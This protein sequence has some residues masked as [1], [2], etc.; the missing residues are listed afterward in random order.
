MAGFTY[1]GN[2]LKTSYFSGDVLQGKINLTLKNES[3]YSAITSNFNGSIGI[4]DLLQKNSFIEGIDYNCSTKSCI[5]DYTVKSQ[6]SSLN[7][8]SGS[9]KAIGFKITGKQIDLQSIKFNINSD[10]SQSCIGQLLINVLDRNETYIQNNRYTGTMCE[11]KYLGCFEE[12]LPSQDYQFAEITSGG[13]CEKIT[14][15]AGPAYSVGAKIKNSTQGTANLRMDMFNQDWE[16]LGSCN[17]PKHSSETQDLSCIVNYSGPDVRD[18]YICISTPSS[19]SA[20]YQIQFEQTQ[21]TCGTDNLGEINPE[22]FDKDY[23]IF[24]NVM[25]FDTFNVEVNENYFQILTGQSLKD[26]VNSY[27]QD[28]YAGDCSGSGCFI[29]LK[30]IAGPEQNIAFS[31]I[32]VKYKTGNTL[33]TN[34]DL[35]ELNVQASKISS[36]PLGIEISHAGITIPFNS[37]QEKISLYL[38]GTKIVE[39][40]P[41]NVSQSFIFD[42]NPKFALLGIDTGFEAVT[43]ESISSSSWTFGDGSSLSSSNKSIVHKYL[44]PGEYN[45]EVELTNTKGQRAK[46]TFNVLVGNPKESAEKLLSTYDSRLAN[47]SKE[48][49][50]YPGWIAKD[51]EKKIDPIGLNASLINLKSKYDVSTQDQEYAEIVTELLNLKVPYR[52]AISTS[53]NFPLSIGFNSIDSGYL[54]ELSGQEISDLEKEE[55]NSA[56]IQW[57]NEN[58]QSNI[59]MEVISSFDDSGESALLTK[60]K[61]KSTS[62]NPDNVEIPYL[63]LSYPVDGIT[64]MQAYSEK[65]L[66]S[67][68][69][70]PLSSEANEIEFLMPGEIEVSQIGAYISPEINGLSK[71]RSVVA[72]EEEKTSLWAILFGWWTGLIIIT[73]VAYVVLQEW[74]KRHYEAYLFK[75]VNDL[76]NLINFIYNSR[77]SGLKDNEIDKRLLGS[78]WKKEQVNYAFKKI[79]GR[80]TGMFEIPLFKFFE[81]RKMEEEIAKRQLKPVDARFIKRRF[82]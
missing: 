18:Y 77:L 24:A 74:Y 80:R 68:T 26:Y 56:I 16:P 31:N 28:K 47:I 21:E 5:T 20:N 39:N 78:G 71:Y 36:L 60:F 42:V 7:M 17:L 53:G 3:T 8:N 69:Y 1:N 61:I 13:Y 43:S 66:S 70:I 10:A 64:F 52:I 82:L 4:L 19:S 9:S 12:S 65:S 76:Y 57:Y 35:Y 6:I 29:P 30:I 15:P 44:Q 14:M 58:Y 22:E 72:P 49:S 25:Q 62:K 37:S 46:K 40:I 48:I 33:I 79:D 23:E 32:E 45:L 67:G 38:N 54:E 59:E 63:F 81:D 34:Y 75:N 50:T 2:S 73:F 55:I 11:T 27:I 51:I 41:I